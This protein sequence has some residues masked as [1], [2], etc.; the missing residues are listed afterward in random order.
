MKRLLLISVATVVF[1][2]SS[3]SV[4][5]EDQFYVKAEAGLFALSK[6]K[7]KIFTLEKGKGGGVINLGVGYYVMDNVRADVTFNFANPELNGSISKT[8]TRTYTILGMQKDVETPVTKKIKHR[9][10][11]MSLLLNSYVNLYDGSIVKLFVGAGAGMAQ[12]KEKITID[13][14]WTCVAPGAENSIPTQR[15]YMSTK[16][17]NNFAYQLTVG[18]AINV[19]K[20]VNIDIVCSSIDY[21]KAKSQKYK[22]TE[23]SKISYKGLNLTAGLRFDI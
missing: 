8:I 4:A 23:I 17:V 10:R 14:V 20:A 21:G 16:K 9:G 19:S 2:T 13:E 1:L 11:V 6:V 15:D 12:V 5:S 7:D 22:D 18:A 3:I